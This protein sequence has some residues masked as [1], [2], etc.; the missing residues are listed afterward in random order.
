MQDAGQ[1]KLSRSCFVPPVVPISSRGAMPPAPIT[2]RDFVVTLGAAA[3]AACARPGAST[4]TGASS[5]MSSAARAGAEAPAPDAALVDA[6]LAAVEARHGA[7][8]ERAHRADVRG[9]I[10]DMLR[11]ADRLRGA[12][13]ANAADPYSVCAAALG[14]KA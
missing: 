5:A 6:L 12:K 4:S 11:A 13:V 14:G 8:F 10:R 2:R 7:S 9:G 3:L 1:R